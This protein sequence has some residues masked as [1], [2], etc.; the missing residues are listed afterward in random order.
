MGSI[1]ST[2][3]ESVVPWKENVDLNNNTGVEGQQR[4]GSPI[5]EKDIWLESI[6]GR[7]YTQRH[8]QGTYT[9][10]CTVSNM[11]H[12]VAAKPRINATVYDKISD[13]FTSKDRK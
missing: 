7:R 13:L 5:S 1:C 6:R 8:I 9:G 3:E 2:K 10:S 11:L 12:Y 4:R